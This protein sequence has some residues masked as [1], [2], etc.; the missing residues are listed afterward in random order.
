M[1]LSNQ[2]LALAALCSLSAFGAEPQPVLEVINNQ[3]FPIRMP[4]EA[5][6]FPLGAGNW[7]TG[8][9][10]PVQQEGS[11]LVFVAR[12]DAANNKR[13]SFR[14]GSIEG[15]AALTIR[16]TENGLA[17][18][19]AGADFGR[20]AWQLVLREVKTKRG[21]SENQESTRMDFDAQFK[22]LALAFRQTGTGVV[23]DTWKAGATD[24]GLNLAIE[25]RAFHEGFVDMRAR[26]TNESASRT[27]N[28]YAAVVCQWEQPR[29]EARS[30][31]YDN[32][33]SPMGENARSG[34]REGE[35]RHLS[36]RRCGRSIWIFCLGR[37]GI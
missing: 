8:D 21:D 23:F 19:Y 9:K 36:K 3:P 12:I 20:L 26:L 13:I 27:S 15:K 6:Q 31:C 17:V 28:V 2:L 35:G 4:V 18:S 37:C 16:G 22:P 1:R 10:E 32:R 7:L 29:V 14:Q 24:A 34:F 11:N 5:R 30:L 33:I 25:A